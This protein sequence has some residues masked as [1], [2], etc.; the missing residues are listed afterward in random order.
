MNDSRFVAH[1]TDINTLAL[2][3]KN[4]TIRFNRLDRVDDITEGESFTTLKLEKFFFVSC[5]THCANESLPQW[6]MYTRD[7]AGVRITLPRRMFDYKPLIVP[8]KFKAIVEGS[9]ISP[10][11]FEQMF[12]A[13][14]FIPPIFLTDRHFGRAV[15]Y[16]PDFVSKKND[17]IRF[18]VN[19]NGR[20]NAQI[21]DPTGIASLKGPDWVFQNEYRFVL[22][23]VPS[24]DIPREERFFDDFARQLPSVVVTSLY[25]GKGPNLDY[26]DVSISQKA[27]E[28]IQIT[29]GPLC[30]DGDRAIVEALLES[31][32]PKGVMAK[33]K[34]TGTIR[35][36]ERK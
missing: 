3:L 14:Y 33:S 28:S 8:D 29:T 9:L 34:F 12:S 7:M 1:Y 32:A 24:P 10:I 11:P 25:E 35:R 15:E 26:L 18:E 20:V 30:S 6:N 4:R 16:S 13:T 22:F 23:I 2:I 17:A 19:S 5:W 27:I 36:P 21:S 31:Y